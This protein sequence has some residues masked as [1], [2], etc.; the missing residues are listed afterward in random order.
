MVAVFWLNVSR[1][2]KDLQVGMLLSLTMTIALCL[3][4]TIPISFFASLSNASAVREDVDWL[5]DL[6]NKYPGLVRFTEQIAPLLVV[7]LNALLP[8][9]LEFISLF[10]GPISSGVVEGECTSWSF[11]FVSCSV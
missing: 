5:D 10:E 3:V 8:K 9:I 1:T 4:W 11:A 6:L 2:H 7:L